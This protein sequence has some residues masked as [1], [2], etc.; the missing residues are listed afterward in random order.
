MCGDS[1]IY[2]V[3]P[4]SFQHTPVSQSSAVPM[5][6]ED[7]LLV[8]PVMPTVPRGAALVRS[9]EEYSKY[10]HQHQ[11]QIADGYTADGVHAL[12]MGRTNHHRG[13]RAEDSTADQHA[14]TQSIADGGS[15][16]G[17]RRR[18]N[19]ALLVELQRQ[20]TA[21]NSLGNNINTAA[22]SLG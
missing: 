9:T 11:Q 15:G 20:M 14:V 4:P 10:L 17:S 5:Y 7:T 2:G 8:E 19:H 12:C 3:Y 1:S 18:L 21:T 6:E 22:N 13:H 16:D